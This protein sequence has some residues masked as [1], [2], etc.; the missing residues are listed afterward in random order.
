MEGKMATIGKTF[1]DPDKWEE[2]WFNELT[3]DQ[4]LLYT[5]LWERCDHA[6]V[7]QIIPAL[8]TIHIGLE[9][10][11]GFLNGLIEA[12]NDDRERIT[13]FNKKLW[14][15]EYIRFNQQSDLTKALSDNYS[16]HKHVFSRVKKHAL[17][18]E[19]QKRDP[20]LLMNFISGEISVTPKPSLSPAKGLPKPTGKGAGRG[21]GISKGMGE[22]GEPFSTEENPADFEARNKWNEEDTPFNYK[23][24]MATE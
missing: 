12:V 4:K 9:I 13:V 3:T 11:N 19:I 1:S 14:F 5:Y 20:I 7:I 15:P 22:G 16:F 24:R 21:E 18:E 23:T 6:G 17:I 8:W 10:D 2:A